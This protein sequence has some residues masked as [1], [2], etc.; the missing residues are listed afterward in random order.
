METISIMVRRS[1]DRLEQRLD[2]ESALLER[3]SFCHCWRECG[4]CGRM[5]IFSPAPSADGTNLAEFTEV[6]ASLLI[7]FIIKDLRSALLHDLL[8]Y[9]YFYLGKEECRKILALAC[10]TLERR[11]LHRC[12]GYYRSLL[13][14]YLEPY[15]CGS[16]VHLNVEGFYNFRMRGFQQE[17]LRTLDDAVNRYLA[18]EEHREFIRLLKYFL[19]LQ[20]PGVALIHLSV[21]EQ[22]R[23]KVMDRRFERIDF[24]EWEELGAAGL[25]ERRDYED[26]LVSMLVSIAPRQL[27]LHR[28]VC[29]RYPRVVQNLRS[30]FEERLIFCKNCAYCRRGELYLVTGGRT[31]PG[32]S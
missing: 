32:S 23:F 7:G 6:L 2:L 21:D 10:R 20:H 24:C 8:R 3:L 9:F 26:I 12:I 1:S 31:R 4:A 30:V 17:L 13:G 14:Q 11:K 28:N 18:R 25:D 22:G 15:R 29:A 27:M 16:P 19:N 5:L